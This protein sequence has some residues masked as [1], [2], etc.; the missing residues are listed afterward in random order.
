MRTHPLLPP[1]ATLL[2][3]AGLWPARPA[4]AAD[5]VDRVATLALSEPLPARGALGGVTVDALGFLYVANFHDRVWRISPEGEVETLARGFY[6]SSGNAIDSRGD[7]YQ[8]NFNGNT[9]DRVS[10]TG[11]VT[12]FADTGLSGP[13]GIAVD[14]DDNLFVCNCSGNYLAKVTPTG[15]VSRFAKGE[16]FSCPNGITFGPDGALY[17]TNYNHLDILRVT[18]EGEASVF[19]TVPGGAGNAHIAFSKGFFYVTKIIANLVVKVSPEGEV[20]PLAGTGQPGDDD[21]PADEA[22]FYRPNG[23]ALSPAGDRIYLNTVIGEHGQPKPSWIAV[24]VIEILTLTEVLEAA[25]EEGG[26]EAMTAAYHDYRAHPVR[27]RENTV[28]EMISFGYRF[29][30]SRQVPTALAIFTL[31][32]EANPG[33]P[34]AHYHLGEAFRYTGQTDAAV[35]Q[36]RKV[37]ELA[38]D[39]PNARSRLE[40]LGG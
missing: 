2:L 34:P 10:R 27:G 11:G 25:L 16:R 5:Y 1:L 20:F 37:L 7:L 30:S 35:E 18:P 29:L 3:V 31:N 26:V 17:V 13:V 39:H 36:Y 33:A 14:A 9:I 6:G 23:I 22:T 19:T 24:R 15:E 32:A 8:A 40:Q 12:R 28:G 38:P 4:A 21:G